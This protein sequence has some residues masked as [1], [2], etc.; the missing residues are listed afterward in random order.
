MKWSTEVPITPA[1]KPLD[2]SG[3]IL[4]LGSCF[5]ASMGEKLGYYQFRHCTNP[6]GVIYHPAPLLALLQ[7]ARDN[8]DFGESDLFCHQGLW[9][10]LW[11]HSSL[12]KPEKEDA[13]AALNQALHQLRAALSSSTH[14]VLT[15]GS[16]RGYRHRES[17]MLA[18]N[19]QKLPA[20]HF[21]RELSTHSEV[22]G[23]V[24]AMLGILRGF[25]P[26]IRCILTVSPVRHIRDGLVANQLS[27]ALLV[28][29]A[30]EVCT[31]GGAGYFPAYEILLDELRDYR[32]YDRDLVHPN[33]VA[34]DYIWERFAGAWIA[35]GAHSDM[36]EVEAVRKGL[37]H[38]PMH[39]DSETYRSFRTSLEARIAYLKERHPHMDFEI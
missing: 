24:D 12:A 30:H 34:V 14:V 8:R 26:D 33:Q 1:D 29:A 22:A 9:R 17:G 35:P 31:S 15:L 19:C 28:A 21:E 38:R 4:L 32:F 36:Q 13:L 16:A 7:R 39:P 18:A 2:Y 11:A 37:A 3:A 10:S 23:F 25:R 5:A 20:S 27:K 6:F